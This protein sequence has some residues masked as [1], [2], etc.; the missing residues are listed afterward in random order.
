MSWIVAYSDEKTGKLYCID[1]AEKLGMYFPN[2]VA[3]SEDDLDSDQFC[4]ECGE[5]LTSWRDRP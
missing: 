3:C 2:V 5:V 4:Q 1:C